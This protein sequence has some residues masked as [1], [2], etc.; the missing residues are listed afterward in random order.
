VKKESRKKGIPKPTPI[1]HPGMP[2]LEWMNDAAGRLPRLTAVGSRRMLVEN[3]TG[4]LSVGEQEVRL[5]TRIG[6]LAVRG[7]DLALS[8]VRP[9]SLIVHGTISCVE[10]PCEGERD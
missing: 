3:H 5:S 8:E 2:A 7:K 6:L 4:I 10:L 1:A 9:G